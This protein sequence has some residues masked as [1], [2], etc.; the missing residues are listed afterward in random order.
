MTRQIVTTMYNNIAYSRQAGIASPDYPEQLIIA[1]EPE[2]G[3][4]FC[5]ER[6]MRDFYDQTG[7]AFV[8]D[9]LARPGS[10][11]LMMDIGGKFLMLFK[12]PYFCLNITVYLGRNF[13]HKKVV[14]MEIIMT[15][16]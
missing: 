2:G 8:S 9:V 15:E 10:Q 13:I 1:L 12:S 14:E 7:D 3:A 6:K 16:K 5:R 4:I 11:Y